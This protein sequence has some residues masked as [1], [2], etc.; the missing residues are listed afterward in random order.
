MSKQDING[1][2]GGI[3]RQRLLKFTVPPKREFQANTKY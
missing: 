1:R 2:G 3:N